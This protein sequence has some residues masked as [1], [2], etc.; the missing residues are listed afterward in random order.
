MADD[1]QQPAQGEPL[2]NVAST[3]DRL[4]EIASQALDSNEVARQIEELTSVVLDSAEVST[5]SASVAADISATMRAVVV[6]IQ[7]NNRRNILHS[8]IVLAVFAACLLVAIGI[9]LGISLKMTKSIKE[10]D[11]MIY[12]MAKRVIE[13]DAS[14]TAIGKTNSDFSELTDKQDALTMTQT[15]VANRLEELSKA[16]TALPTNIADQSNKSSDAKFQAMQKQLQGLEA[17]LQSMESKLQSSSQAASR[18]PAPAAPSGPSTQ[19]LLNEIQKLK[20]DLNTSS[21][22]HEKAMA[23]AERAAAKATEKAAAATS[24]ADKAVASERA[25]AAERVALQ[26]AAAERAAAEKLAS[27][28]A[29]A[30][31]AAAERAAAERAAAEKAKAAAAVPPKDRPIQYP[32]AAD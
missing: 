20:Q 31:K 2:V 6:K 14:L 27:E 30:E 25:A 24:A 21:Q 28:R 26:K 19:T 18:Q 7:S 8:R 9:F 15:Q 5:R 12:A 23:A 11:T 29:A 32:R 4:R 13:V 10:L 3:A 22:S 16:M 17:K 1:A